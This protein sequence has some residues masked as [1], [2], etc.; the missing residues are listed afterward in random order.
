M[1]VLVTGATG[2]V[3]SHILRALRDVSDIEVIAA[4]RSLKKLPDFFDGEVRIG[5]FIDPRYRKSVMKG[6]DVVCNTGSFGTFWGHYKQ[7][8]KF[9][10][11]PTRDLIDQAIQQGV[12]RFIQTS[13]ITLGPIARDKDA[14]PTDDFSLARRKTGFWPHVDFL[15]DLDRYMRQKS[16]QGMQMITMRLGHFIGSGNTSGLLPMLLPRMR[17]HMVPWLEGGRM[18]LPLVTGEDMGNAFK[19]AVL[20]NPLEK[21]ESF[22]IA[23]SENPT[24]RELFTF[25]A[26]ET[27]FPTPHYS[28]SY[29]AAY[30]FGWLM[31]KL[32]TIL[33]GDP[34][35]MRSIVFVSENWVPTVEYAHKKLGYAPQIDWRGAIREQIAEIQH[36]KYPWPRTVVSKLTR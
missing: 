25:L 32:N 24:M 14:P 11:E 10:Y 2:F 3:G 4:C 6:I 33:P 30:A 29:P 9:F 16:D 34:F 18:Q 28:V 17:T 19:L 1:K 21:Y 22:N 20:A 7:E 15:M 26:Q 27:G 23:G 5:D 8:Q 35:L 31:E 36:R 12:K 13:T